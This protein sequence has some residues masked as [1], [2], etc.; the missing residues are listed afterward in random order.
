MV[1]PNFFSACQARNL[2]C[3]S[4]PFF[5]CFK[6]VE[7]AK[8]SPRAWPRNHCALYCHLQVLFGFQNLI[9][10]NAGGPGRVQCRFTNA[11]SFKML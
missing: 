9:T 4:N 2:K 7:L 5:V 3:F 1:D 10:T 8:K 6:F 11:S